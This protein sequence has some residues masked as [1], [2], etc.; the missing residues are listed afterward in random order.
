MS[1]SPSTAISTPPSSALFD[2]IRDRCRALSL[3][4][5]RCD[6]AGVLVAEPSDPGLAGLWLRSSKITAVVTQA[7]K[8]WSQQTTTLQMCSPF[9]GCWLIPIVHDQRRRRIALTV[10]M[11]LGPAAQTAPIYSEACTGAGL[12][13]H[14]VRLALSRLITHDEPSARRA[15]ACLQW[16]VHDLAA[17]TEHTDAVQGFTNE[18]TQSYETIDLLYALGRSMLDLRRPEKFLT[19]VC[20]RLFETLPFGYL[21][22]Q[23][24]SDPRI[25]G[26][27]AGRLI[28]RGTVPAE[29]QHIQEALQ[30]FTSPSSASGD[31]RAYLTHGQAEASGA[32]A[33]AR[34]LVQPVTLPPP[35]SALAAIFVCGDKH[36]E[37]P[38]VSSYDMQLLE[39]AAGF[40]GAFIANARFVRD[41]QAMFL[42]TVRAL[43]AAIDAKDRYTC[44]H[45]ER[46]AHLAASLALAAGLDPAQAERVHIS[47]LVHD[48]GKIGV[49][50]T[51][52]CKPGRLTPEEFDQVKLHPGIG[53]R[54]LK[55]IP[56][57]EDV[58]PAVLHHHERFDGAGYPTG[59]KGTDIPLFA[60]LICLADTFDAM[61]SNRSY[62]PAMSRQHVLD[63]IRRCAGSQFD[64]ELAE[65]FVALD[66][67]PYDAMVA[68]H[69]KDYGSQRIVGVAA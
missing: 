40:T 34:V 18:L 53:H 43:T 5:W 3:A 4:T 10:A 46:V 30:R 49:P 60:R 61:S 13:E 11:A 20:N 22:Y 35:D 26:D 21:A 16:T 68:R 57:L 55:D 31:I 52:L 24:V 6:T 67:Q 32:P 44:G 62:R 64:P 42:G 2:T 45:S 12:D 28:A 29:T 54:I 56:M 19:L 39:A 9:P 66:L 33:A 14:A 25:A 15:A 17:L 41:Q 65:K 8:A 23:M 51:I 69:S 38:Q 27:L 48:V 59:L 7:A 37:D 58:L 63:E 1:S 36:G 47:G 50:E